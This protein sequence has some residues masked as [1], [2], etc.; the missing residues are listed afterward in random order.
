MSVPPGKDRT[1]APGA[2]KLILQPLRRKVIQMGTLRAV[3]WVTGTAEVMA[4]ALGWLLIR[5][6]G[7]SAEAGRAIYMATSTIPLIVAPIVGG[8]IVLLLEDVEEARQAL[9]E[10]ST[11]DGLTS[12]FNR[13]YF[14]ERLR[15]EISYAERYLTPLSLLIFDADD[16]KRI[17]DK[18]GHSVGDLVLESIAQTC[19]TLLREHDVLARYGG[20]EF[21]LLLPSTAAEGAC[22]VAEKLRV[23]LESMRIPVEGQADRISITV[24]IGVSS[25]KGLQDTA[26]TLFARTD[27]ALYRAKLAGKNRWTLL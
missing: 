1:V 13:T 25:R 15:R 3:L 9:Q 19:T 16:F 23:A 26:D 21:V 22:Q 6:M 5:L 10:I 17:N 18:Y 4:I 2:R 20:E 24:S 8:T 7:Y 12:L 14:M 11:H 27:K